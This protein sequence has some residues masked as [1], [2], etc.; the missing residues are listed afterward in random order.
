MNGFWK[1]LAAHPAEQLALVDGHGR[2]LTYGELRAEIDTIADRFLD[3][4][5]R[6]VCTFLPNDVDAVVHLLSALCVGVTLV[7]VAPFASPEQVA[8]LLDVVRPDLLVVG[9]GIPDDG[10]IQGVEVS[11]LT[12]RSFGDVRWC[13]RD[14]P[15]PTSVSSSPALITFTSGSTGQPKGV[16]LDAETLDATSAA[17]VQATDMGAADRH[18]CLHPFAVL[19]ELV[20]GLLRPLR[21]GAQ[22]HL[23][24]LTPEQSG[25]QVCCTD[26][27]SIVSALRD[28]DA[29]STILVPE[30]LA[31]VVR[32]LIR[33]RDAGH[34]PGLDALRFLGVGGAVVPEDLLRRSTTLGLPV[35]QGYGATECGSVIALNGPSS[36]R[37]G[38]VGR[39][40]SHVRVEISDE[41]EILVGGR[42][43]SGYFGESPR[44]DGLWAT[45][46]LGCLDEDGFLH[47]SGRKSNVFSTP[48]G[49]N[50]SAEWL[51]GRL[52][53][54]DSVQQAVVFGEGF[55]GPVAVLV[56]WPG[57][58]ADVRWDV[59]RLNETL[60]SYARIVRFHV[61]E[62]PFS[63]SR[64][65]W[66]ATGRPK[67]AA[68]LR[69]H[70]HLLRST[71][72][73]VSR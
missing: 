5:V 6:S 72:Q 15:G 35:F 2:R 49:R 17:L 70:E 19:L 63:T 3:S 38:S 66:C 37:I 40:L 1:D 20:G 65:H 41:G 59:E 29:T 53:S 14:P 12:A 11:G 71:E 50:V 54:M 9:N 48:L 22:V 8:H 46:D 28:A 61:A 34:E 45:G 31:V 69:D 47:L 16:C 18:V 73:Q 36:N 43:Y 33:E 55:P 23:P 42:L 60:P 44:A 13:R 52:L 67:R 51:E 30:M 10:R 21:A 62:E 58:A 24:P 68:I 64:G 7:P 39:P 25:T 57:L 26:G 56:P 27:P 32:E 4:G